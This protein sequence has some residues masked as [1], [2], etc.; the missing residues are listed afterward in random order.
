MGA[1]GLAPAALMSRTFA[2]SVA[3]I[4]LIAC[5]VPSAARAA[6]THRTSSL[7]WVELPGAE[8]CGGAPAVARAEE[9]RLGRHALV[10]PAQA[11]LSIEARVERS[12]RPPHWHAVMVLRDRDGTVLGGRELGSAAADCA[13]LRASAAL[14]AALMIDPD[15]ALRPDPPA[16][17]PPDPPPVVPAPPAPVPPLEALASPP[18][19]IVERVPPGPVVEAPSS[20]GV[21]PTAGFALGF[22]V[23]PATA[24]GVRLGITVSPPHFWDLALFGGVWAAQTVH[25]ERGAQIR[26]SLPW[27]GLAVC[28]VHLGRRG[29]PSLSVCVG[30]EVGFLESEP[31]DFMSARSSV[32]PAVSVVAPARIEVPLVGGL[33]LN[34][35]GELA[36]YLL[37]DQFVYEDPV[38]TTHV[39]A[40]HPLVTASC[41]VGLSLSLP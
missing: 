19:V 30:P 7:S 26:F 24:A 5:S 23:L 27:A 18:Q 31:Q 1:A 4:I 28:P 35:G 36:V 32:E 34:L 8:G 17:P 39:V 16:A 37:R 38:T 15:A 12:G 21:T 9:D 13:E 6:D 41:D 14:A 33:G 10:S 29:R 22:G 40:S 2:S 20:W 25:A 3:G 11:D